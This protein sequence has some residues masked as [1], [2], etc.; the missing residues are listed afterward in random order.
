MLGQHGKWPV[1]CRTLHSIQHG[2][3]AC[4]DSSTD[5]SGG[6][7]T[8]VRSECMLVMPAPVLCGWRAEFWNAPIPDEEA[9]HS[10]RIVAHST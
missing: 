5:Y 8:R 10:C 3:W 1:Q 9:E 4:V 2:L 6:K 7:T